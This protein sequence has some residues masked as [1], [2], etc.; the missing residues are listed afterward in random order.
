GR[1]AERC[2]EAAPG[3]VAAPLGSHPALARLLLHRYDQA[4]GAW[5]APA[6]AATT[7]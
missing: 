1:F 4:C 2:A 7:G 3:V 5:R 6:L